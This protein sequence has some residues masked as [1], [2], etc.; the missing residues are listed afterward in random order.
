MSTL[1][2]L[3][4]CLVLIVC[5]NESAVAQFNPYG[6]ERFQS[7]QTAKTLNTDRWFGTDKL[8]HFTTSSFLT[9]YGYLYFHESAHRSGK[10]S[11]NLSA[12]VALG[13]GIGKEIYDKKSKKGQASFKDLIADIVG[14]GLTFFIIKAV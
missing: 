11:L 1:K 2:I 12:G 6:P 7:S 5:L 4:F 9:A 13:L 8:K 10:F 14:V 3:V